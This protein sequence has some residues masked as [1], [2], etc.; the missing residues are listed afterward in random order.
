ML[1]RAARHGQSSPA[2]LQLLSRRAVSSTVA[3]QPLRVVE[4]HFHLLN[5][6]ASFGSFLKGLGAPDYLPEQFTADCAGVD[7][8]KAVHCE[9]IPTD[10]LAEALYV[11][12][13]AAAGSHPP[14]VGIVGS[15]DLSAKDARAQLAAMKAQCPRL[16]GI[17][18][19]VDYDGPFG[20]APAT[21]VAVS[22][23]N[24]GKGVDFLRDPAY[25]PSFEAGYA[26]LADFGLCF[27]LQCA[28]A[29]LDAA[30]ALLGRHPS[31][32]VCVDRER[33]RLEPGGLLH[34]CCYVM[35][36]RPVGELRC[37]GLHS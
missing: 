33:M 25:A 7:I 27:E 35:A 32:R 3:A 2:L 31:I 18:Y 12:A 14:I 37:D 8:A 5:T 13:V 4:P 20:D 15:V 26:A 30:A 16:V 19:M 11:E 10:G 6:Q 29:Q 22:R 24:G 34:V 36:E 23:H 1:R 9:I 28:P 21:H 17:R